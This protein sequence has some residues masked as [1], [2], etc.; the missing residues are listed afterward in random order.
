[1]SLVKKPIREWRD[2][3]PERFQN[4][5]APLYQ[6]AVIRQYLKDWPALQAQNESIDA[7]AQY[8]G[9]F[10]SGNNVVTY[11]GAPDIGGRFFYQDEMEGF[12]F[13]RVQE[14]FAQALESILAHRDNPEPP[15][16]YTGAVN[17]QDNLPGFARENHCDL[18][19]STAVAR[20]WVG[21]AA[22]VSTHYDLLDNIVCVVS[23]RRR[24]T[25]FPPEQL[26]NLYVGPLD[27]TLSGQ[28]VSMVNLQDPDFDRFPRFKEAL[29][30]AEVAELEPGDALYLPKLWWHHVESLDPFNA[31]V[32]YWWDQ[33]ALGSDTAFTTLM[34]GLL[35]LRHLPMKEKQAWQAFFNH[36][37]FRS[38]AEATAH[39]P[40]RKRGILGN[41]TPEL[42][43]KIKGH[44]LAMINR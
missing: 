29:A 17:L 10:D 3:D 20:I 33:T 15:S 11:R 43:R 12:N 23:G 18:V 5:I 32:N 41:M 7:L 19:G 9:R 2:V 34:H 22:T 28:P 14:T 26:T 25:L 37:L 39:I 42:Y 4:E 36:Y 1:M 35:T 13:D 27:F 21:N 6:P 38:E 30:A 16:I 8:I 40:E 31:I 44:V 24:F